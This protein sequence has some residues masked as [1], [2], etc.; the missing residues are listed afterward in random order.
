MAHPSDHSNPN[1]KW[2]VMALVMIG[3][4]M[5]T[6]DSSIVNVS[7]PSIMADFGSNVADIEWVITAYMLAFAV[8][9]P[10]TAWLRDRVGHRILYTMS[11]VVFTGGSLLC[12]LAWNIPTLIAARVVQALGGGAMN[13][14]G[15]AMI[16]E[17]FEPKERGKAMGWFGL[18]I[19]IG[20]AFGPTLGGFLTMTLGWRSIFLVNLPIGIIATIMAMEYL[21]RDRPHGHSHRPFDTWGFVFLS[22]FLVAFLLGIS[23]GE[24]E[25]WTSNYIL[26]CAALSVFGILSFLVTESLVQDKI[27]DLGLLK[28]PVFSVSMLITTIRSVALFG[29]VFLLPLFLQQLKGLTAIQSG[30][31]LLPGSLIIAVCMPIIG[32]INN[33]SSPRFLAL[34]G[35][36]FLTVSMYMYGGISIYMSDWDIIFPTLIRGIGMSLLMA[37]IMTLALNAVPRR[38]AGMASSMLAIIQQ[39]GGAVGIAILSTVL[40]NRTKFHMATAGAAVRSNAPEFAAAVQG[41]SE[42]AHQIGYS[43]LA[44]LTVAKSTLVKFISIAQ[45][46]YAFQDTF[47]FA[48]VLI[49]LSF[50]PTF[51]LPNRNLTAHP[52]DMVPKGVV[53]VD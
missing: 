46:N 25:G 22:I 11:L 6:L 45:A 31:L 39:V 1:Y 29:G 5:S 36:V 42:R 28:Y 7:I 3:M 17:V 51:L 16:A 49:V 10:V 14:T 50:L 23:R 32:R 52:E 21:K 27:I 8:L 33:H 2:I 40:D 44:S 24:T 18:G 13:P 12:G 4:T 9:M 34:I 38:K 53:M 41:I 19:I 37:P 20:P 35:L 47:L 26:I 43:N 30:L 15:M 48:T